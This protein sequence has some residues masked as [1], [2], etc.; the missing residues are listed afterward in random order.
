[1]GLEIPQGFVRTVFTERM[2][3]K[4]N[5]LCVGHP[6]VM[7]V[8]SELMS[9]GPKDKM[10][11]KFL[12]KYNKDGPRDSFSARIFHRKRFH[13]L[14]WLNNTR[15]FVN[16]DTVVLDC[17]AFI[18]N[19]SVFWGVVCGA[20]VVAFEGF[21]KNFI[22]L[23]KNILDNNLSNSVIAYNY[24]LSS[25]GEKFSCKRG[26]SESMSSISFVR[27]TS[28][29]YKSTSIDKWWS[30]QDKVTKINV[31]KIDVEGSE[32]SLLKGSLQ[33]L[34][35]CHPII[36]L[37]VHLDK[38]RKMDKKCVSLLL[39]LGYKENVDVFVCRRKAGKS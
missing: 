39:K 25:K 4:V 27:D 1:M 6:I 8:H 5:F 21:K 15:K 13:D 11:K 34:K 28:G 18:G 37:E 26:I 31:M 38:N 3:M 23:Q 9:D 19:H 2:N 36:Y 29:K 24:L 12:R 16:K 32:Y 7:S 20:R 10:Y 30:S 22:L 14:E 33:T 17:G 35:E